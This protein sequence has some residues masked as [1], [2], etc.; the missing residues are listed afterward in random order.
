MTKY[1]FSK[2]GDADL[3]A[4]AALVNSAYRGE[5]SKAGWTTEADILG[6]QRTDAATLR[7]NLGDGTQKVILCARDR[8]S[9]ELVASVWLDRVE[10]SRGPGCHLGM[11]TVKPTLQTGGL[12]KLLMKEAEA[13]AQKTWGASWMTLE[14]IQL[15]TEL[16]AWYER[17]GYKK[18][19]VIKPFP[20]NDPRFGIPKVELQLVVFEKK[21]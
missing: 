5:S 7:E 8:D 13:F 14:V 16:M 12:G 11:L 18:T 3:E 21:L 4:I 15:R 10:D 6:G 1:V 17:R 2:C 20:M 9:G 19:G